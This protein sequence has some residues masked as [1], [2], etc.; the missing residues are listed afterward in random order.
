MK[1]PYD[2]EVE[3]QEAERAKDCIAKSEAQVKDDLGFTSL[4]FR[5]FS[6]C[7][8]LISSSYILLAQVK[9]SPQKNK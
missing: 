3:R 5:F 8:F 1:L 2:M 4:C 9:Q 6:S 7:F